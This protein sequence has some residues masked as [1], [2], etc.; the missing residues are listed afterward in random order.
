MEEDRRAVK[1]KDL[2]PGIFSRHA[3]AY[4]RRLD[5]IMERGEARGRQRLIELVEPH[6]GMHILDLA[7]GPGTLTRR[8]ATLVAPDGVV[9]GVDLAEGMLELARAAAIPNARFELMDISRLDFADAS[10]DAIT[11]GHGL[12]FVPDLDQALRESR[13]VLRP[14]APFAAS[15][16]A[17]SSGR[18]PASVVQQVVDRLLPPPP[19]VTDRGETQ[20]TVADATL[21]RE[22][23]ESAG[24]A[25]ARV[26]IVEEKVRWDSAAQYVSVLMSWWDCA[27]RMEG[28]EPKR[29]QAF[30]EEATV[31]LRYAYP[32][33]FETTARNHVLF[34]RA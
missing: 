11:C 23:A 15:F 30:Q 24:F 33:A 16:P 18:S 22:A 32:G 7:C 2:I 1:S 5:Q 17:D 3:A 21:L 34:G 12:Q 4:Q 10:F 14:A 20:R 8:L 31:A 25:G 29:L 27:A 28:V 6:P 9:V 13:R 19:K 26:E